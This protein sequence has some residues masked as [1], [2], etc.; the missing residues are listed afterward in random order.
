M[1]TEDPSLVLM[2]PKIRE[3]PKQVQQML[4]KNQ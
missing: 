4:L 3:T 1:A 2:F